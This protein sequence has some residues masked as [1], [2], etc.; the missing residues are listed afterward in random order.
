MRLAMMQGQKYNNN[1]SVSD[2]FCSMSKGEISGAWGH[3]KAYYRKSSGNERLEVFADLFQLKA[4]GDSEA[5]EFVR[6]FFPDTV[7]AFEKWVNTV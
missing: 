5:I 3:S 4:S 6:R 7:E 2:I 1:Q